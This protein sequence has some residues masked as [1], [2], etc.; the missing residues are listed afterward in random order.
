MLI[1]FAIQ[2][3]NS[4]SVIS[5]FATFNMISVAS[6]GVATNLNPLIRRNKP[7]AKKGK[8]DDKDSHA[9]G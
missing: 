3:V 7:M 2:I 6:F 9:Q 5:L 8:T 1:L 4:D